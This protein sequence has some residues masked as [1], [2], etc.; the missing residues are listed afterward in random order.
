MF[1]DRLG[2]TLFRTIHIDVLSLQLSLAL[3]RMDSVLF[4]G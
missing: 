3:S 1:P 2:K 4:A